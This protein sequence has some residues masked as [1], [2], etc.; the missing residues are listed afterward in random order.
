MNAFIA[1]TTSSPAVLVSSCN[2]LP[3]VRSTNRY[4]L[5]SSGWMD[6]WMETK[7]PL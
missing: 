3:F 2:Q 7:E 6:G 4:I 1:K 5:C